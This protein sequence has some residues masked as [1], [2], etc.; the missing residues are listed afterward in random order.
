MNPG[1]INQQI[2]DHTIKFAQAVREF[3]K[4]IP[5]TVSNVE[6][7]KQLIKT[8][9]AIGVNYIAATEAVNRNDSL[10]SIRNCVQETKTTQYWLNLV[11]MQGDPLLAQ[12]RDQLIRASNE[13]T[14]I[15]SKILQTSRT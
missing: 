10:A 3:G 8:S 15:F 1:D 12:R 4:I 14:A 7:L 2:F 6:D 13:L 11:D 5:M 9:G